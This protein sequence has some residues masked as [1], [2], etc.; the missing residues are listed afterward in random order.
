M[1]LGSEEKEEEDARRKCILASRKVHHPSTGGGGGGGRKRERDVQSTS[2]K[3]IFLGQEVAP[4]HVLVQYV[5]VVS[6]I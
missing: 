5:C 3:C 6:Y 1:H 4:E 2:F